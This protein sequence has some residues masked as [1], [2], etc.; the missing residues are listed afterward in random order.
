MQYPVFGC[1]YITN[2]R[3]CQDAA[4]GTCATAL[5]LVLGRALLHYAAACM[6]AAAALVW[7]TAKIATCIS[8]SGVRC[9][10]ACAARQGHC[11]ECEP[12]RCRNVL[13]MRCADYLLQR[14]DHLQQPT[15]MGAGRGRLHPEKDIQPIEEH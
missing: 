13:H 7:H 5:C 3:L 2:K 9:T 4:D 10:V 14:N 15:C 8:V 11:F 12:E 6:Q 1:R